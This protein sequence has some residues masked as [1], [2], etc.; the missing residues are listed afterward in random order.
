MELT[1]AQKMEQHM[2]W[3]ELEAE[4]ARTPYYTAETAIVSHN[5]MVEEIAMIGEEN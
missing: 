5:R 1:D 2:R 3:L 4:D